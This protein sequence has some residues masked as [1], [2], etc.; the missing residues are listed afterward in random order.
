[1]N[2]D[3]TWSKVGDKAVAPSR[4]GSHRGRMSEDDLIRAYSAGSAPDHVP[5]PHELR[6]AWETTKQLEERLEIADQ[7]VLRR[8]VMWIREQLFME[9]MAVEGYVEI[10]PEVMPDPA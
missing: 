2:G 5:Q 10:D 6:N 4:F 9:L 1:M 7:P 8:V 3:Q